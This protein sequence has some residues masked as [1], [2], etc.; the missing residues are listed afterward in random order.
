VV[1]LVWSGPFPNPAAYNLRNWRAQGVG[2][3]FVIIHDVKR[4]EW[5]ASV[6]VGSAPAVVF[7]EIVED[8]A[9]SKALCELKRLQ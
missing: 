8:L 7:P 5:S 6:K 9:A 1:D 3:S 2:R 4:N